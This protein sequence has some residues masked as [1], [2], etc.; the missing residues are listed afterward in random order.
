[1]ELYLSYMETSLRRYM[2]DVEAVVSKIICN[3]KSFTTYVLIKFSWIYV[4]FR[5]MIPVNNDTIS[6][7]P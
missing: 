5:N 1:M 6:A 3:V 4:H 2:I 7:P